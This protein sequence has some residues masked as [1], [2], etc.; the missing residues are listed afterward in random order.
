MV[1]TLSAMVSFIGKE[2]LFHL[3][4][5]YMYGNEFVY[6][7]KVTSTG[8]KAIWRMHRFPKHKELMNSWYSRH[9]I[10]CVWNNVIPNLL[11]SS[12]SPYHRIL[13]P[14]ELKSTNDDT[15][16]QWDF[17]RIASQN[18]LYFIWYMTENFTLPIMLYQWTV[19][20]MHIDY[21]L[22]WYAPWPTPVN[23][24]PP[25]CERSR[26]PRISTMSWCSLWWYQ[27]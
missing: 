16:F 24:C 25:P 17:T 8:M 26:T 14:I 23:V 20:C 4:K 18:H 21:I 9:Q 13:L 10:S 6:F 2:I 7:N 15:Y 22:N 11:N 27:N 12:L 19:Y 3:Q 1:L 5:A